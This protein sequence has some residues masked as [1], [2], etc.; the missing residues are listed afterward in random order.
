MS[1][2]LRTAS[3][4]GPRILQ[5]R[6]NTLLAFPP[7]GRAPR[8]WPLPICAGALLTA[9][10]AWAASGQAHAVSR[11]LIVV[12]LIGVLIGSL[13]AIVLGRGRSAAVLRSASE[14]RDGTELLLRDGGAALLYWN[15]VRGELSWSESFFQ[16]IQRRA[17]DGPM[18]YRN[19]R[20]LLHP[21]D[22]LYRIVDT[23]I[24]SC[25]ETV[26]ICFRLRSGEDG[27]WKWFDLRG[28]IRR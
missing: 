7:A 28:R 19:M 3:T 21:D 9:T 15:L 4:L 12:M 20:E 27:G 8:R 6:N 5:S 10:P 25:A 23:H 16:M 17:P 14:L 24:R 2:V 13:S 1:S 26:R 11:D 18:P 22:D